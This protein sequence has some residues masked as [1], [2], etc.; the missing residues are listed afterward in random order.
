MKKQQPK[1]PVGRPIDV[2]FDKYSASHQKPVNQIINYI[3]IPF[4]VFGFL[5]LAWAIPFP[6]LAFLGQYAD[7]INWASLLIA[8]SIYFY[9]RM[10]PLLS[11]LMLFIEF[12]LGFG[13][14]Q[15]D[16]WQKTGGPGVGDICI[17]LLLICFVA[18]FIGQKIEGKRYSLTNSVKFQFYGPIW[19]LN[20]VLKKFNVKY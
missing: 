12:I 9:L 15:L 4:V 2:L 3:T 1:Q 5:G 18:Q 7:F 10:S 17:A 8:F 20:L 19:L 14:N 16:Q 6:H 13:V 11:Y